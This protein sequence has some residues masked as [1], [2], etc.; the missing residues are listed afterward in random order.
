MGGWQ[1][2]GSERAV[3]RLRQL[4]ARLAGLAPRVRALP[5]VADAFYASR[6]WRA[7]RAARML[8]GDYFGALKRARGDG[9]NGRAILDHAHEI[10]DGGARLDPANTVW[11]THVEHQA[12]T[13]RAR[14]TRA[15]GGRKLPGQTAL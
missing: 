6:E 12:K 8:D 10:R 2:G 11:L 5:K 1:S 3:G 15:G 14:A 7:L 13:A 9:S 4:P